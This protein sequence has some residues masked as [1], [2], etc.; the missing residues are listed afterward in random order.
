[1]AESAAEAARKMLAL[2]EEEE[3]LLLKRGQGVKPQAKERAEDEPWYEDLAE[4]LAASGMG[5]FYGI[6]ELIKG[7]TPEEQA[8]LKDWQKDAGQS[9]Y[10]TAGKILGEVA[11]IAVPGG[12]LVKGARLAGLAKQSPRLA[13]ALGETLAAG[14]HG[15]V[16]LPQ[17]GDSRLKQATKQ[18]AATLAGHGIFQAGAKAIKGARISEHAR[19]LIDQGVYLTPGQAAPKGALPGIE[20]LLTVTPLAARRTKEAQE[21]AVTSWHKNVIQAAAPEGVVVTKPGHEGFKQLH[22]GVKEA[23]KNA[24]L[25]ADEIP[26]EA[27]DTLL[28]RIGE[29]A[30][31]FGV[32]D[33]RA[34]TRI[35][36]NIYKLFD[37]GGAK[38]AQ[39]LDNVLRREIKKAQ[40]G[41][42]LQKTLNGLR[43]AYR[44]ALPPPTKAALA[45]VDA[46]YPAYLTVK[47]AV[48]KASGKEGV[49][50]PAQLTVSSRQVGTETSTALG[51]GPLAESVKAGEATVGQTTK[52]D[53]ELIGF[54]RRA[55]SALSGP[56]P[57][58][59]AG[60]VVL[61]QTLPQ[62]AVQQAVGSPVGQA[63]RRYTPSTGA[64][65][66]AG[67]DEY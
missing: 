5:T 66:G 56:I 42:D 39:A 48:S 35:E 51:A 23:Y 55:L 40:K 43:S 65:A 16:T 24:W 52:K 33:T 38:S 41:S 59:T 12:A 60:R 58:E 1:M 18:A 29:V 7:L 20:R 67:I 37:E 57:M 27:A 47:K 28:T 34:F 62:K 36:D 45:A 25:T 2:L 54:M 21:K 4:G 15:A 46:K 26:G 44:E 10:G 9:G 32:E 53:A 13:A 63:L 22:K 61:G 31:D 19:K 64:I 3:A 14:A 50:T 30:P 6:K 49:F 8:R 11:Q 17:E